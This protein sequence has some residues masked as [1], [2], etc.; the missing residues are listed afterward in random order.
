MT[1]KV[2]IWR[3]KSSNYS[4]KIQ[5]SANKWGMLKRIWGYLMLNSLKH[6]K[7]YKNTKQDYH[8]LKMRAPLSKIEWKISIKKIDSSEMKSEMPNKI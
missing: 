4:N 1:K 6:S 8:K 2:I 7:N 5:G 3:E